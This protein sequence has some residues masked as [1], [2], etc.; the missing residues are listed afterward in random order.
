MG[1]LQKMYISFW[2]NLFFYNKKLATM[3][4][5][6]MQ[7]IGIMKIKM[8]IRKTCRHAVNLILSN[9]TTTTR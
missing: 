8:I 2:L 1:M 4:I 7:A 5:K 3:I 9:K 6:T